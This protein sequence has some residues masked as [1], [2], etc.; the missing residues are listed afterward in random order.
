MPE[1]RGF[2]LISRTAVPGY[3]EAKRGS[4]SRILR[5]NREEEGTLSC[6]LEELEEQWG[7]REPGILVGWPGRKW[8]SLSVHESRRQFKGLPRETRSCSL[9]LDLA[10]RDLEEGFLALLSLQKTE[11]GP[12]P[13][14]SSE[15]T[16][17]RTSE[18]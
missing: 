3:K 9:G 6:P 5:A 17:G 16:L 1:I 12:D 14:K 15:E 18:L 4:C 10:F 8:V 7:K 13:R 11:R 2:Q